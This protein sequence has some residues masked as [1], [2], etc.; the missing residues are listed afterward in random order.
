MIRSRHQIDKLGEVIICYAQ[1][2]LIY[3]RE[4][5]LHRYPLLWDYYVKHHGHQLLD[6]VHPVCYEMIIKNLGAR[7]IEKE[8][9]DGRG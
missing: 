6:Y 2:T 5:S 1:N 3:V 4:S 9:I 7:L 8:N